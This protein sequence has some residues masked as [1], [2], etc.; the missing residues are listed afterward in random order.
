MPRVKGL[1]EK[2]A[3]TL[4]QKTELRLKQRDFWLFD[5]KKEGTTRRNKIMLK[6]GDKN[7]FA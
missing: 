7:F 2:V 3:N 5:K 6:D 1:A 4:G